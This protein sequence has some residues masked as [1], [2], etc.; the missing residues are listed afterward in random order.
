L[1]RAGSDAEVLR[2]DKILQAQRLFPTALSELPRGTDGQGSNAKYLAAWAHPCEDPS[3][4]PS[5]DM[6]IGLGSGSVPMMIPWTARFYRWPSAGPKQPPADWEAVVNSRILLE[7][8]TWSLGFDWGWR[9]PDPAVPTEFSAV[10]ATTVSQSISHL[11]EV[12]GLPAEFFAV[13]ATTEVKMD[14]GKY[15]AVVAADNG[16]RVF[17]DDKKVLE[18][19]CWSVPAVCRTDFSVGSGKHLL[20]VEY[21]HIDGDAGLGVG[22]VPERLVLVGRG[23]EKPDARPASADHAAAPALLSAN[24]VGFRDLLMPLGYR[25]RAMSFQSGA[26]GEQSAISL[27]CG[28]P[29]PSAAADSAAIRVVT[30]AVALLRLGHAEQVWP[31]LR[32]SPDPSV[33]SQLIHRLGPL[34]VDLWAVL[35]RLEEEKNVSARRALILCLGEFGPDRLPAADRNELLPKLLSMYRDDPDPGIHGAAEW[36]LRQWNQQGKIRPI[37]QQLATGKVEGGLAIPALAGPGSAVIDPMGPAKAGPMKPW[38]INGQ[39]HT[40]VILPGPVDFMMGSLTEQ[41]TYHGS[42]QPLHRK[43]IERSFAIASKEV[44]MAQFKRFRPA[45]SH[46]EMFHSPEPD[47]PILGV[48]W[49]DATAYCNWLSKQEGMAKDQWCYLP[50]DSGEFV[51]GMRLAAGWSKRTGYRLPTEAEWE[52]ACRAGAATR[53]YFGRTEELLGKY[54][55]YATTTQEARTFQAAALK[56]NDFGLFDMLGNEAEWCQDRFELD[57]A[58]AGDAGDDDA[59]EETVTNKNT[60]VNRGGS[61][62]DPAS[63][64]RSSVRGFDVPAHTSFTT[65]FRVARTFNG[66]ITAVN[67]VPSSPDGQRITSGSVNNVVAYLTGK[68]EAGLQPEDLELALLTVQTLETAGRRDLAAE[69]AAT[70]AKL[71]ASNQDKKVVHTRESLEGAVRRLALTGNSIRVEGTSLDGAKF[72]WPAYRGKVVL[73]AFWDLASDTCRL[74]LRHAKRLR[75]LYQDRGFEVVGVSMDRNRE[76]LSELLQTERVPWVTLHDDGAEGLHP[77]AKYYGVLQTPTMLIVDKQGKV[78]SLQACGGELDRLLDRLLGSACVPTGRLTTIDL[79]P[80]ANIKLTESSDDANNLAELPQGE[81]VLA[82]V[83]FTIGK[84]L[85]Q[86]DDTYLPDKLRKGRAEAISVDKTF[87]RLYILHGAQ[88]ASEEDGAP[89]ASAGDGTPIGQYR[90]HYEDGTEAA[91]PIVLGEDVRDWWNVDRSKAATRGIV[92]WVGQNAATR[93]NNLGLRLYLAVW[94]NPNPEKKVVGIDFLRDGPSEAG[95][96][97]VAMTVEEPATGKTR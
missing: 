54:A 92:A 55:W 30:A 56:P 88:W 67:G 77:M 63:L 15:Y 7:R 6:T 9:A 44:T 76:A 32:H 37:D 52:Y 5:A 27:D 61:F 34:G 97:C 14:A 11:K 73:L 40:M 70:L 66:R 28:I 51:E 48:T 81:Q 74:E 57:T 71:A 50:N 2:L 96:F 29:A 85:I 53:R 69:T 23:K 72:D 93:K 83:K 64:V 24:V 60:R 84:S 39:G 31:L 47:C 18:K 95:P 79:Q 58:R 33:R 1:V 8:K 21:F 86:L 87:T 26:E 80:K 17:V 10:V 22:I 38:Y 49:Y 3:D 75:R 19:W 59:T 62:H 4:F 20:R 78:A 46:V 65:G 90:L 13:V 43:R 36:L 25:P 16:I 68:A 41:E 42:D 94:D 91:M 89:R 35:R 45:F 82:G 12:A